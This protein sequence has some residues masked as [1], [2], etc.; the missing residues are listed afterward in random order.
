MPD[1]DYKLL[2]AQVR[3]VIADEPDALANAA[4]FVAILFNAIDD[5]NW[6][7]IYVLRGDELVLGPFQRRRPGRHR[8]ALRDLL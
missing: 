5:I 1:S 6:L 8:G 4:N 7:G 2:N 3:A